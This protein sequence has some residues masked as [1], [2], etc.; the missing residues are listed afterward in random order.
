M[1]VLKL[2]LELTGGPGVVDLG[3]RVQW[4]LGN[5]DID[6]LLLIVVGLLVVSHDGEGAKMGDELSSKLRTRLNL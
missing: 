1:P 2:S 3:L 4:I 6:D 5:A